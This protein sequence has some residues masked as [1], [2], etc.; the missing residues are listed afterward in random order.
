MAASR[1]AEAPREFRSALDSL[2]S[3]RP[4]SEVTVTEVPAPQRLAPHAAAMSAEV[5]TG[6]D[7]ELAVGRLVL[8]HDP[9][10][11]EEWRGTFRFVTFAQAELEPEMVTDPMLPSVGWS[12]LLESLQARGAGFVAPSGTVT[13]VVSESFGGM[14]DRPLSTQLEVRASWSP[15]DDDLGRHLE[16]WCELLCAAAGLPPV[17]PGVV[18]M[19]H[20]G[21][22][23]PF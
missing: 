3:A 2:K 21:E 17:Q 19:P 20:R 16:A 12:W 8:L 18:A 9:S 6:D 4:R 7:A 13:R 14:A 23:R 15:T 11:Q 10:G 1:E 22:H 5:D